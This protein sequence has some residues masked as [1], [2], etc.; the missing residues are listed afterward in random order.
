[1]TLTRL[2]GLYL[3]HAERY[4]RRADG[5]PTRES[6]NLRSTLQNFC[7]SLPA[8]TLASRVT[9]GIIRQWRDA[10]AD[11]KLHRSTVN[12]MVGR[13][14]R[15]FRWAVEEGHIRE[16]DAVEI[17]G[18]RPLKPFRSPAVEQQPRRVPSLIDA[19]DIVAQIPADQ[20]EI[21]TIMRLVTL[22]GARIGEIAGLRLS[23][24]SLDSETPHLNLRQHKSAHKSKPRLI[25]LTPE[26]VALVTSRLTMCRNGFLFPSRRGAGH[27]TPDW[28][29][30]VLK[31]AC[32]NSDRQHHSPHTFR[33]AVARAVRARVGLDA[34]QA[35]LGHSSVRTTEIYCP[36]P[37]T[38]ASAGAAAIVHALSA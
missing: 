33:H 12:Q 27:V 14:K 19:A 7:R 25:P 18:V 2:A 20:Q 31:A 38:L 3:I 26:A 4:Y 29:R 17:F 1:M 5:T 11:R 15:M 22:T 6:N 16:H 34:A 37:N 28:C 32:R 9:G 23:D 13:I 35:L 8:S 30:E 10:L 24:V 21:R 36:T